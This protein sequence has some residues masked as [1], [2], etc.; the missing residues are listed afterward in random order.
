[1]A[2]AD[3]AEPADG[4][5]IIL[6]KSKPGH[7]AIRAA[8]NGVDA[9]YALRL[10][11]RDQAARLIAGRNTAGVFGVFIG[12]EIIADNPHAAYVNRPAVTHQC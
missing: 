5:R 3:N 9:L 2:G 4:V 8:D 10:E 1:M 12:R 6:R 11:Q 7:A